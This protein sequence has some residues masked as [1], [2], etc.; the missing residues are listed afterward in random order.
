MVGVLWVDAEVGF[1][2]RVSGLW[3]GFVVEVDVAL[4][5]VDSVDFVEMDVTFDGTAEVV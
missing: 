2:V 5:T 1:V 4:F 3:F